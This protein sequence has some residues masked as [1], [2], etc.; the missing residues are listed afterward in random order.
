M[1][2]SYINHIAVVLDASGSMQHLTDE[3]IKVFD[4]QIQNLAQRSKETNQETRVSVYTFSQFKTECIAYDLDV[5]R[6]PSIASDYRPDGGTPLIDATFKSIEDLEKTATLYGDHAF[7]IFVLTDGQENQSTKT[8]SE[9]ARK[10]K[11]LP[12]N[13]TLGVFVPDALGVSEAKKFGFPA[14]NIKQWSTDSKGIQEVG[15]V[16]RDVTNSYM[17]ARATGVRGTKSL[18]T[19]DATKLSATQIKQNLVELKDGVDYKIL[20]VHKEAVIKP[21][22]ESW[23]L[24]FRQGAAYYE[25][26]KP[27]TIQSGKQVAVQDKISGKIYAGLEARQLLGLPS[28]EVKVNPATH[29]KFRV[30]VQSTSTNRK[31]VGGTQLLVML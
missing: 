26:M 2:Q 4:A 30:F 21:F 29:G 10:I 24:P 6:L 22:V 8:A 20:N 23:K 9:L 5:L 27:E 15:N 7:L 31:L 1:K 14:E 12:D 25:L 19:L 11:S 3:V 18:F 28:H 17:A 16:M 13:W